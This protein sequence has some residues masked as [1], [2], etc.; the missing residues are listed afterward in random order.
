MSHAALYDMYGIGRQPPSISSFIYFIVY[1]KLS[2]NAVHVVHK[3][4]R[5]A[6]MPYA[7]R[8]LARTTLPFAM[9][10]YIVQMPYI[11]LSV[12]THAECPLPP[13]FL[14]APLMPKSAS[15]GSLR[16]I[17]DD[18]ARGLLGSH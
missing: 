15:N 18:S 11:Y 6:R 4:D 13:R 7:E 3:N 9:S 2:N 12:N 8:V 1:K 16:L 10:A 17:A 5:W 14:I